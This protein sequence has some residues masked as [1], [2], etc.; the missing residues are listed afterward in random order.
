MIVLVTNCLWESLTLS[1]LKADS[2]DNKLVD[3]FLFFFLFFF[4]LFFQKIGFDIL[5]KLLPW[6]TICVKHQTLSSG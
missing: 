5:C 1:M 6:E 2:A 4:F 3:C